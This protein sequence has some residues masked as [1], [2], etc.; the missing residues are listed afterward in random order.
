MLRLPPIST[1]FPYTTLFRSLRDRPGESGR[2][3]GA[4]GHPE[5]LRVRPR[6][7]EQN[8]LRHHR[9][10]PLSD[11]VQG[12]GVPHSAGEMNPEWN[13]DDADAADQRG[14]DKDRVKTNG[15]LSLPCS[16][17]IRANPPN[18]R[19]PRSIPDF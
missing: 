6:R 11:E 4:E 17:L 15:P 2:L 16:C 7:G 1:L 18:P 9:Q 8:P 3:E 12:R 13:A 5:Q 19:H 14:S 10:E